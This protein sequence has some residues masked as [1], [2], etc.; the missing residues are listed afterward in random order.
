MG[1][2]PASQDAPGI[3]TVVTVNLYLANLGALGLKF[4]CQDGDEPIPGQSTR[5]RDVYGSVVTQPG[6][7]LVN[8]W[9]VAEAAGLGLKR[10]FWCL[11]CN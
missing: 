4:P 5:Y 7:G 10:V 11:P 2:I 6:P 9:P 8:S 3:G 1:P